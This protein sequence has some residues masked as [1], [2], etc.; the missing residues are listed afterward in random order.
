MP[1]LLAHERVAREARIG[2]WS[3]AAYATRRALRPRAVLRRRNT[4]QIVEGRVARVAPTKSRTYLNFGTD[5]RSDF[6]AGIDARLLRAN[7][8]WAKSLAALEGRRI[9]VRGW[10]E[11]RNGPFINVEDPSQIE[12]TDRDAPASASQVPQI[13][14][15]PAQKGP[16][17]VDL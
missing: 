11:Y 14:K 17:A 3:H 16:G 15:R 7:P 8:E 10:I 6:T 13:R 4:Y 9:E 1:E 2:L 12:T 5:W